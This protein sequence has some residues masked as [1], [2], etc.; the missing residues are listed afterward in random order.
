MARI[1]IIKSN[2]AVDEVH[3]VVLGDCPYTYASKLVHHH[4]RQGQD[5]SY[6]VE[7]SGEV[8]GPYSADEIIA[9]AFLKEN[10]DVPRPT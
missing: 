6:Q 1:A 10:F 8:F 5:F 7:V 9:R 3:V 4:R 2:G